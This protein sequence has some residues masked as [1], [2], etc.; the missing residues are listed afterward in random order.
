LWASTAALYEH[1]SPQ[2]RRRCLTL[3]A[4]HAPDDS[5]LASVARHHGAD[6]AAQLRAQQR[7]REQPLVRTH[8][9]TGR[10]NLFL[11]PLYVERIV[12]AAGCDGKLLARLNSMLDDP[13]V[14]MRWRWRAGDVVIWDETSTCHRALTDHYPQ[15]RV[16]RR[17]VVKSDD[18]LHDPM[19]DLA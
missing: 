2:D 10:R 13:H 16:M 18:G 4:T 14:Q 6:A 15:H 5:L 3:S 8:P 17:C 12:G 7:P 9:Q 11:S 1:L 19:H